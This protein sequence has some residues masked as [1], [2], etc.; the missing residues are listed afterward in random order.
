MG[1]FYHSLDGDFMLA[2]GADSI[3]LFITLWKRSDPLWQRMC[4]FA[5]WQIELQKPP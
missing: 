2:I 4:S 5:V 1:P 3:P